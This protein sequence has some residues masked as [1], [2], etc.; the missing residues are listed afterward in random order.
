MKNRGLHS[1]PE[2]VGITVGADIICHA[3]DVK[4]VIA[5][6]V[7]SGDGVI[8]AEC[9]LKQICGDRCLFEDDGNECFSDDENEPNIKSGP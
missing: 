2:P 5:S 6:I 8:S 3:V 7:I 9:P 1:T 4:G